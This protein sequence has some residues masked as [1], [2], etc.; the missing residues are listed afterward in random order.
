ML[1]LTRSGSE[2]ESRSHILDAAFGIIGATD[3][4]LTYGFSLPAPQLALNVAND[5]EKPLLPIEAVTSLVC[6]VYREIHHVVVASISLYP[7][8]GVQPL[9]QEIQ[10]IGDELLKLILENTEENRAT[11]VVILLP[12]PLCV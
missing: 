6:D 1:M 4:C 9:A 5:P 2:L 10:A 3:E 11:D 8:P 7:T 12:K